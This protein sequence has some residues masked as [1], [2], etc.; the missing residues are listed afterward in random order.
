MYCPTQGKGD[1]TQIIK[2]L[3]DDLDVVLVAG[4]DGT[5]DGYD[6]SDPNSIDYS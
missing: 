1:A 2:N 6:Y 3:P 4:G 5:F